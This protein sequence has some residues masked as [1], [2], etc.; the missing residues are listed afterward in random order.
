MSQQE[1]IESKKVVFPLKMTRDSILIQVPDT[2]QSVPRTSFRFPW[3]RGSFL[4]ED[5]ICHGERCLV[6]WGASLQR[7]DKLSTRAANQIAAS[8]STRGERGADF[9]MVSFPL[10]SH[11]PSRDEV[12]RPSN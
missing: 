12:D 3:R 1:E 9:A 8:L 11:P 2:A 10:S 7:G 5:L 4:S 6:T